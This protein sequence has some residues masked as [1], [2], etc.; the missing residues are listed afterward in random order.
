MRIRSVQVGMIGTNCYIMMNEDTKAGLVVDPGGDAGRILYHLHEMGMAKVEGIL[1][2]HGHSDHIGGLQELREAVKAPVYMSRVDAPMLGD[3]E[4]NLSLWMEGPVTALPPEKELKHGD[5]ITVAGFEFK[6]LLTPGHTPGGVCFYNKEHALCFVGDTIFCES[7]GR[8]DFP[9]GSYSAIL[10][11]IKT[12]ILPLG[13]DVRLLP[14]HMT[15]TTVGWEKRRNP[16]L[17]D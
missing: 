16:Y 2:T 11:S 4:L 12:Q 17:Q 9:G 1:V 7:I 10:E 13:D 3:A 8:T 6:V 5:V 15:E 14:G